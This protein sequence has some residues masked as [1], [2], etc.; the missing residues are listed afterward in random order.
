MR[1]ACLVVG[2][3][4]IATPGFAQTPVPSQE[5]TQQPKLEI[6]TRRGD[7]SWV[8][9]TAPDGS[10]RGAWVNAQVPLD[11]IDRAMLKPLSA[12]PNAPEANAAKVNE[13]VSRIEQA[14][15]AKQRPERDVTTQPK[16][17]AQPTP[18]Q[19][20]TT[21]PVAR[22]GFLI[23]NGGYQLTSNNFTD[24][25]TRRQ[26][27]EDGRVDT[28][29]KVNAGPAFNVAAGAR[30]WKALGVGV[31]VSRFSTS[32]PATLTGS[33]PNPFFFNQPRSISGSVG[34]LKREELAVHVQ[35]RGMLE[36]GPRLEV[37]AFG[38]P[39]FFQV[40]QSV[41]TDFSISESYPYD[42]ATFQSAITTQSTTSKIGVNAGGDVA[43]FFTRQV[44]VGVT[45]QF[46]GTTVEIEGVGG[47][48]H[49]LKVGGGTVGGGLRIR[50]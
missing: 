24:G 13:R 29:Y 46:A 31:G 49:D 30:V 11:R 34:G 22:H 45:A 43:F 35:A 25:A 41:V 15:A 32:T 14:S 6:V 50:F 44:G 7:F 10:R 47:A 27:A 17:L 33:V 21:Q 42:A 9:E 28:T 36:A 19:R 48:K 39:S 12:L 8:V 16:T 26:Y 23:V 38:G 20:L 1:S 37:M 3:L 40:K 2:L 18:A 4:M 5:S